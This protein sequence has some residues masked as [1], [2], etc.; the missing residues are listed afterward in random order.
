M[1]A[2]ILVINAGSSSVKSALFEADGATRLWSGKV[3]K[4]GAEG[5]DAILAELEKRQ[6]SAWQSSVSFAGIG[7]R[8]VHGGPKY[9]RPE[10]V[11]PAVLDELRRIAP[12]DPE[13][14]PAEIEII[15]LCSARFAGVPQWACFDTAFHHNL[16]AVS[17]VLPIPRRYEAQGIRRY[18][19]H[20]LSYAYLLE[21]LAK[22]AGPE[23][24]QGR[25]IFAHL[26]AGASM[27]AVKGGACIDTTMSL[28]PTAG[29][30]M[31]TRSGDLDPGLMLHLLRE[32]KL[33][34]D[35]LDRLVNRES[36]LIGISQ[37]T[38][39]MRELLAREAI[40][41]NARLAV[42]IFAYQ[43]KKWIGALAAALQGLDT[44]VF[45]GG[46][47]ENSPEVRSRICQGLAFLGVSIDE[48]RNDET[49][50]GQ[51]HA[52]ISA[53][54]R[55]VAVRVIPTDEELMICRHVQRLLNETSMNVI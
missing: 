5:L 19:F 1:M 7:H 31:A 40:D 43:A 15:D 13:H 53:N 39:D 33:T 50:N 20:G 41:E 23:A 25:V 35:A 14:L 9:D 42:E 32:D 4:T 45:S 12:L 52:V 10:R 28:T 11:S 34:V 22:V 44:L 48:K 51:R 29:L 18:G 55:G 6:S 30:V 26:G 46:I 37:T 3:E 2:T 8:V 24:A 47:G 21:E 17:R 38:S 36:G 54:N 16:P 49:S 27:A